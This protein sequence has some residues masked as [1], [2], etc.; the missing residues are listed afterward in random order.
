[1]YNKSFA[2][3]EKKEK[4]VVDASYNDHRLDRYE[5]G[6]NQGNYSFAWKS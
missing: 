1:M 2:K 3:N 6:K 4:N 5:V